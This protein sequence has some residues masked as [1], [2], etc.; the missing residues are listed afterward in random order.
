MILK[1]EKERLKNRI[2][3]VICNDCGCK[4]ARVMVCTSDNHYENVVCIDKEG[5]PTDDCEHHE[6]AG[7]VDVK[8]AGIFCP[9]CNENQ[10]DGACVHFEDG[11]SVDTS[12]TDDDTVIV[13]LWHEA[14]EP[15]TMRLSDDE[16]KELV[17]G[18]DCSLEED[19][20]RDTTLA[21]AL[22]DK[23]HKELDNRHGN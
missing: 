22:A 18:L 9:G 11:T 12:C 8:F 16:L 2:T 10:S 1:P 5:K 23:I 4:N 17:C 21:V 14:I 13:A 19:Q 6:L 15:G 20:C 3:K 7:H